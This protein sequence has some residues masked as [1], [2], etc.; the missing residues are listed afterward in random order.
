MTPDER[1]RKLREWLQALGRAAEIRRA[2]G[3]SLTKQ[4]ELTL[5][6]AM[7]DGETIRAL[8][9]RVEMRARKLGLEG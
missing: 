9:R 1:F 7:Q 6:R 2:G 4:I 3:D 8:E 5:A